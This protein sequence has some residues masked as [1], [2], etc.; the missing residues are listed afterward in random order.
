MSDAISLA[1]ARSRVRLTKTKTKGMRSASEASTAARRES[2]RF[3]QRERDGSSKV[4][5]ELAVWDTAGRKRLHVCLA[6]KPP[7][8]EK[9]TASNGARGA[10]CDGSETR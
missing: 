10:R 2:F 8:V 7:P 4:T 1:R 3:R 5:A 9:W 6:V